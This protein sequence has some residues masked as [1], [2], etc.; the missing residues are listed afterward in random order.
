MADNFFDKGSA[1]HRILAVLEQ[2]A[3]SDRPV[4]PTEINEKLNLPKATIHRL[5]SKLEDENI[6]QREIDGKRFM[7]GN[8]L[9]QIALGTINNENF[10]THRHAILRKLSE[11]VGETCNITIPD[12][13]HMRY[14]ERVETHWPLRMQFMIGTKVPLHCTASGKLF[15]SQLPGE[16]MSSLIENLILEQKTVNT[17]TNAKILKSALIKIRK[18]QVGTDNEEFVNGMVAVAVPIFDRRK[19]FIATL[20]IHA[21]NTRMSITEII[22][23]IPRMQKASQ[24]LT[25]ILDPGD[26]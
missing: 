26:N 19:R 6:L 2:V 1:M 24:D 10:R 8:R 14:L 15:L 20:S 9:R 4:T 7:P 12:G 13:S 16:Q 22:N 5:C 21:P 11:E 23:H 18:E 25:L 3:N 17:L